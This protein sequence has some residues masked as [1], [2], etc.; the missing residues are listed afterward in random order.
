MLR[1]TL[2]LILVLAA[3]VLAVPAGALASGTVT[4]SGGQLRYEN[5]ALTTTDL[6]VQRVVGTNGCG[7]A[8][9][10]CLLISDGQDVNDGVAGA[11]CVTVGASV[12]CDPAVFS[13]IFLNLKDGDDRVFI[14]DG[15]KPVTVDG[16]ADDD[17]L[18]SSGGGDA[19]HGGPGADTLRDIDDTAVAG[20]DDLLD[21]GDGDDT[22]SLG[23]GDDLVQGGAGIDAV[24]MGNG[25]DTL[26]L[27][28][29]ANDGRTGETKNVRSDVEAVDGGN[30]GDT[31]F[32]NAAGNVL[33]GGEGNDV[34]DAGGGDDVL[35]GGPGADDLIGG[36]AVDRVSY[37]N[38]AAQR[39]SLDGVRDDGAPGELDNV[40]ADV[41]DVTAGAGDD[42]VIGNGADNAL[43]GGAGSDRLDGAGGVD[44]YVG[45]PGADA[46]F[47][48]DGL[49]ESVDCGTESD[50]GEADTNDELAACEGLALSSD[51]IPD[52]D[53]D[54]AAKP[55]DCD[56][57]NAAIKP[58]VIDVLDNGVDEDCNG[59][60]AVNLDRDGDAFLRPTDCDDANARI[61]PGAR[62]IPGNRVDED[63][64]G[65][66]APFPLL[67]SI[68]TGIFDST[69]TFSRM[70]AINVR[71]PVK[72]STL[73]V[74][75]KG[76]G[77]PFRS[78]TR[79]ITRSR[80]RQIIE[81]PLGKARLRIGTTVELR[82]TRP[83]TVGFFVRFTVIRGDFPRRKELCLQPGA[84]RPT[85]C[86]S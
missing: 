37:S 18:T 40:R 65:G 20:G 17:Q 50:A 15:V 68:A 45:G 19:L 9:Q 75:C 55:D 72:G 64:K 13:T 69:N 62:D 56:D 73:K 29:V 85:R 63:C 1:K 47:A 27:D 32:G 83:R 79:P 23:S 51:L 82:L 81:R 58:G 86:P 21:G 25:D 53:G 39:I 52:A 3:V 59:A 78:R 34:I 8:P 74:T 77:C 76:A 41:E 42:E 5:V 46:V 57:G 4:L 80:E 2:P 61:N 28:D 38:A 12:A 36:A 7:T 11:G 48:R 16:G 10:P 22:I 66:P 70:L 6:F 35:E 14:G 43:D 31:M 26:R 30:G 54:G 60:D 71:R 84:K 49:R 67:G 44:R 33:R 24:T